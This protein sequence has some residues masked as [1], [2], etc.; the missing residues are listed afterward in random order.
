[1]PIEP[2]YFANSIGITAGDD[3]VGTA[4][5]R[6]APEAQT[7]NIAARKFLMSLTVP[8]ATVVKRQFE[9]LEDP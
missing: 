3:C 6:Y 5:E 8:P 1:M 4:A 9:T 7:H 2:R